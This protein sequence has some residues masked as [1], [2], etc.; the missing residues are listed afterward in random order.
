[1]KRE[2]IKL[3]TKQTELQKLKVYI[4]A[5]VPLLQE[6]SSYL[7]LEDSDDSTQYYSIGDKFVYDDDEYLLALVPISVSCDTFRAAL[8]HIDDG[9]IWD[10][11]SVKDPHK[12]TQEELE[13]IIG[14]NFD[15]TQRD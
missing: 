11:G 14:Q 2:K 8:I 1:M 5:V 12:I 13:D 9:E 15:F 6:I 10:D 3:T 4:D 7:Y